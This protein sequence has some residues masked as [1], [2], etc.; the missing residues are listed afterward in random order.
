MS[1]VFA[2]NVPL[3]AITVGIGCVLQQ[4]LREAPSFLNKLIAKAT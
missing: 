3:A 4:K 2:D 1:V